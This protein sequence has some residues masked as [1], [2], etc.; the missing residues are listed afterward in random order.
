MRDEDRVR[1]RHMID[2]AE[3][4]GQ[5]VSGRVRTDLDTDRMLLFAVVRA[6]EIIG[7]AA[8]KLSSELQEQTHDIPWAA[9]VSMRNRLIHGYFDIDTEIVWKTV[10]TEIPALLPRP[11][12]V[13]RERGE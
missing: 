8:G 5:F 10:T 1:I 4:V 3:A 9:I 2:A 12:G 7:E 11:A 13:N 6:I